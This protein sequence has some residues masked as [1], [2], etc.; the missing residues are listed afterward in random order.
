MKRG[1]KKKLEENKV[2]EDPFVTAPEAADA[3]VEAE[4]GTA[5]ARD[6]IQKEKDKY[7]RLYAEFENY[8]KRVQKD[9][10][11]L[12]KYGIESLVSDLLP[13][14]DNLE[15]ALKHSAN[16]VPDGLVQGVEITLKEF[17]KV[18]DKFGVIQI[19]ALD[20]AFD[21][22]LHHAMTQIEKDDVEENTVVE[23]F[24]KGYLLRDKVLRATLVAVSKKSA[25]SDSLP[26]VDEE[27][28]NSE[29]IEE[30]E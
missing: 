11:E 14:V 9:K 25:G 21:P 7:L 10:D 13:V 20:K 18:L 8:K 29:N 27:K 30:E 19:S 26:A 1:G 5:D 22:S 2:D 6:E 16:N 12:V 4:S 28:E 24:R 23:E 3:R 17:L 15:M